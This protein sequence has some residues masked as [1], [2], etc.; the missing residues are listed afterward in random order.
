MRLLNQLVKRS[1]ALAQPRIAELLFN[2][3]L[4]IV[5]G[6]TTED[7][8]A[9]AKAQRAATTLPRFESNITNQL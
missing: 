7:S 2:P 3:S 5:F 9:A 1:S 6:D 8:F 4:G